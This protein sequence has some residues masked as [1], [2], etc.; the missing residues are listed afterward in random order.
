MTKYNKDRFNN[1]VYSKKAIKEMSKNI[2]NLDGSAPTT[3]SEGSRPA[4]KEISEDEYRARYD[5]AFGKISQE[6]FNELK[7]NG[8]FSDGD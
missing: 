5:L 4:N 8:T 6:E 1:R 2:T 3:G 7:Q